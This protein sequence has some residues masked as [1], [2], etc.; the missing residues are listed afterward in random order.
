[1]ICLDENKFKQVLYEDHVNKHME[2]NE[3]IHYQVQDAKQMKT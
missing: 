2:L 3:E 1:M